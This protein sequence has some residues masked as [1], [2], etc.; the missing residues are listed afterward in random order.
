MRRWMVFGV[1]GLVLAA[2][3]VF[4]KGRDGS[5]PRQRPRRQAEDLVELPKT[6]LY[7]RA[8]QEGIPGRSG[9]TKAQLVEALCHHG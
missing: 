5:A 3:A 4:L 1:V 8:R 9:M 6:K 2:G 7:E